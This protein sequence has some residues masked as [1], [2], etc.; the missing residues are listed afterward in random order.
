MLSGWGQPLNGKQ[1]SGD[2]HTCSYA[3]LS[4]EV[5]FFQERVIPL[6]N[7]FV[8]G[9]EAVPV[10]WNQPDLKILYQFASDEGYLQMASNLKNG[11]LSNVKGFRVVTLERKCVPSE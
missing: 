6:S 8:K 3:L 4:A 11:R 5:P 10:S 1:R 9:T 7:K 2:H